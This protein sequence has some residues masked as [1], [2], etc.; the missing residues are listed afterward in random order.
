MEISVSTGT[1]LLVALFVAGPLLMMFSHR[2]HGGGGSMMGGCGGGHS[3]HRGAHGSSLEDQTE[4]TPAPEEP[5]RYRSDEPGRYGSDADVDSEDQRQA[6]HAS[7][8]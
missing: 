3:S 4:P 8:H 1:I 6:D 2:G 5:G 7:H